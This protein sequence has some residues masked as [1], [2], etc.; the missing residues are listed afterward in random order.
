[1]LRGQTKFITIVLFSPWH[2]AYHLSPA[3]G[4]LSSA[5]DFS[6]MKRRVD[7]SQLL[8]K[9]SE[10]VLIILSFGLHDS[11]SDHLTVRKTKR[12]SEPKH[13]NMYGMENSV[14]HIDRAAESIWMPE[15]TCFGAASRLVF[16]TV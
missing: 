6:L 2:I 16:L 3:N 11:C 15:F 8:N 10:N 9:P 5:R 12:D 4:N 7:Q 1:V 14:I 13:Q